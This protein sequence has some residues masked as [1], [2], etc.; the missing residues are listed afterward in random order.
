MDPTTI[1]KS[2]PSQMGLV[3]WTGG[4]KMQACRFSF[5]QLFSLQEL[6]ILCIFL[7]LMDF[8]SSFLGMSCRLPFLPKCYKYLVAE[9]AVIT[10]LVNIF[11][12]HLIK[13]AKEP[14][15]SGI[16][17]S[18]M[19]MKVFFDYRIKVYIVMS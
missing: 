18:N 1:L 16:Q 4:S 13:K 6:I 15:N 3:N 14:I 12:I 19:V 11:N 8:I 7:E 17:E 5:I 10:K 2:V 9:K